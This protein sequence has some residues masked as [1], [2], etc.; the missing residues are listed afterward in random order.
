[1]SAKLIEAYMRHLMRLCELVN[2]FTAKTIK[3]N[4]KSYPLNINIYIYNI[5]PVKLLDFLFVK[6]YQYNMSRSLMGTKNKI[7]ILYV[8]VYHEDFASH[9]RF[10]ILIVNSLR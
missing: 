6:T 7:Q 10:S 1:M 8:T 4:V 2:E 3:R 9:R 5:Y